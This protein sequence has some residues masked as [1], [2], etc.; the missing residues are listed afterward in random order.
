MPNAPDLTQSDAAFYGPWDARLRESN[1]RSQAVQNAVTERFFAA[2]HVRDDARR[3]A[4]AEA[5][6]AA[7]RARHAL[8]MREFRARRKGHR[9]G[10]R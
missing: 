10:R 4:Q 9:A 8:E 2:C 6:R 7:A 5:E 1:T 3:E